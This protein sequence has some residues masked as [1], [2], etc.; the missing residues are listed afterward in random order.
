MV[1]ARAKTCDETQRTEMKHTSGGKG[2][3]S[4]YSA[5]EEAEGGR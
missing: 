4:K 5:A 1:C 3:G 2:S